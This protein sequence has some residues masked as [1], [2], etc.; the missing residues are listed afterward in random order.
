MSELFRRSSHHEF[1]LSSEGSQMTALALFVL[2][3]AFF[4]ILNGLSGFSEVKA[5]SVLSS[6]RVALGGL[7][8]LL[9]E[10]GAGLTQGRGK[11]IYGT[12]ESLQAVAGAFN[13]EVP[14][15]RATYSDKAGIFSMRMGIS[16]FSQILGLESGAVVD[17]RFQE[18]LA[19][20]GEQKDYHMAVALQRP[21]G[22]PEGET[23]VVMDAYLELWQERLRT[24]G[25]PPERLEIGYEPGQGGRVRITVERVEAGGTP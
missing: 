18:L 24:L 4:I 3:L 15:V 17:P 21:G 25:M 12:G 2:L 6:V 14:G 10:K 1:G 8:E 16:T 22:I 19:A 20:L 23:G 9:Q 7:P 13:A 5:P 11:S